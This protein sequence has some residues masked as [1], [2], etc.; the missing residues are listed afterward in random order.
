VSKDEDEAEA[1]TLQVEAADRDGYE[2]M[3]AGLDDLDAW[4]ELQ[5]WPPSL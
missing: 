4:D 1:A 5:E 2:R 3:P